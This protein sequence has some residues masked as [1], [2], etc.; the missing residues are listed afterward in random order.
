MDTNKQVSFLIGL[1]EHYSPTL[2]EE[3]A[4]GF[5]QSWMQ[6]QG[7]LVTVDQA[8]SVIGSLGEGPR[9]ILLLGHIDTVPGIIPVHLEEDKLFGRGSVDAKGPLACF[10]IAALLCGAM[11]G[12][13]INVIGAVGEEGDSRGAKLVRDNF[14]PDICIIGEPSGWDHVTLAYKGSAWFE[15]TV[16]RTIGHTAGRAV[17]ASEAAIQ[18]WNLFQSKV[19]QFNSGRARAFD[20]LTASL[21][22][23]SSSSD[24]FIDQANL[25]FNLRLPPDLNASQADEFITDARGDGSIRLLES[26]DCYRADKNT[27]LVRAML[28]AIRKENGSPGFLVKTGTSDMNIVGPIWNKPIL[29][30]GPGDSSLDHTPEEHIEI[31][32]YLK[33]IQV[34]SHALKLLQS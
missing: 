32:E 22:K 34:L 14:N 10:T 5:M 18:F 3:T 28:A 31:S 21:R 19:N 16:R 4:V 33:S 12:W 30:Y 25:C 2:H 23:I 7:F 8:G 24:D 15:Y 26:I 13:K 17:S 27:V 11:P 1:L 20:Q 9:E 6:E 29:A